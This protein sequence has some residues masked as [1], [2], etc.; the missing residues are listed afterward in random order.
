M[1]VVKNGFEAVESAT[2]QLFDVIIM[3]IRMININGIEASKR[4]K[5]HYN[6]N[7]PKIIAYTADVFLD[8]EKDLQVFDA[9]LYKPTSKEEFTKTLLDMM[10][11]QDDKK[12]DEE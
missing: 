6:E 8:Q 2:K 10:S 7:P 9:I 11:N 4:I 1:V 3:D 12:I 5:S